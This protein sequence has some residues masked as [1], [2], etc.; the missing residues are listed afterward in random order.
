MKNP[1]T[2]N[3]TNSCLSTCKFHIYQNKQKT[4]KCMVTF[5]FLQHCLVV[6]T[7]ATVSRGVYVVG[8]AIIPLV[9][10]LMLT[11]L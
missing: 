6:K 3:N 7:I 8:Q 5:S 1:S 11:L 4:R 10:S 2:E 9:E